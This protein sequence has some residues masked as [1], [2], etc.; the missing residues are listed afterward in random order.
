MASFNPSATI[1]TMSE[2][3]FSGRIRA[4]VFGEDPR[5]IN[6]GDMILEMEKVGKPGDRLGNNLER[7]EIYIAGREMAG[8]LD[9]VTRAAN[10]FTQ[11]AEWLLSPASRPATA[12]EIA[13]H[14]PIVRADKV[15]P[16][17]D[18]ERLAA[19]LEGLKTFVPTL[20]RS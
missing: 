19:H 4:L 5:V 11:N 2:S 12:Q 18:A 15:K 8:L 17:V 13:D 9:Q 7:F 20:K 6:P 3:N 10:L 14:D 1:R 16:M